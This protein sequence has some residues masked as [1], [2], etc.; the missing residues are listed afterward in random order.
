MYNP[1]VGSF[2]SE[3]PLGFLAGD[4]NL[5][6]YVFNSPT[7]FSDPSGQ[8]LKPSDLVTSAIARFNNTYAGALAAGRGLSVYGQV[9]ATGRMVDYFNKVNIDNAANYLA[10]AV[11]KGL[12]DQAQA[13][14]ILGE[15]P[16]AIGGHMNS[17]LNRWNT[18]KDFLDKKITEAIT[19]DAINAATEGICTG[20][21][22]PDSISK[23][24]WMRR[25]K[26]DSKSKGWSRCEDHHTATNKHPKKYT[27]AFN[28]VLG[29]IG[30]DVND[31]S[32]L[33][34][35]CDVGDGRKH[36]GPNPDEYNDAVLKLVNSIVDRKD[37]SVAEKRRAV[38][39]LF[40][41]LCKR[42]NTPGDYFRNLVTR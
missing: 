1:K 11:N 5:R 41:T 36:Y 17:P 38:R 6:R 22:D 23:A 33:C 40:W 16:I 24:E 32:N 7:N 27:P 35:V 19:A 26:A 21:P 39:E 42:M 28:K 31:I 15:V 10:D 3:D 30:M 37:L 12:I 34:V 25:Q 13:E 29:K 2:I 9:T 18:T 4:T 14:Q 8:L 20:A